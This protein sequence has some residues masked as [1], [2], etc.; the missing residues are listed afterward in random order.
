[1]N[2]AETPLDRWSLTGSRAFVSGRMSKGAVWVA[3]GVGTALIG[4]ISSYR[5]MYAV[6]A[7]VA[8]F[9]VIKPWFGLMGALALESTKLIPVMTGVPSSTVTMM[10]GALIYISLYSVL[11]QG[12]SR[13]LPLFQI[14]GALIII[15]GTG[16]VSEIVTTNLLHVSSTLN[17]LLAPVAAALV[18]R[19]MGKGAHRLLLRF[20]VLILLVNA[21]ACIWEIHAGTPEL[22]ASGLKYGSVIREIGGVLRSPGLMLTNADAGVFAGAGMLWLLVG[23]RIKSIRFSLIWLVVGLSAGAVVLVLSTSRSG[24]ILFVVGAVVNVLAIW[25]GHVKHSRHGKFVS[26]IVVALV[27]VLPVLFLQNGATS[28]DSLFKRFSAWSG[29]IKGQIS[30]FGLG[31]GTVGGSSFSQWNSGSSIFVDN[32][33]VSILLQYGLLGLVSVLVILRI[34]V[35]RLFLSLQRGTSTESRLQVAGILA[36]VIGMAVTGFVTEILD[37]FLAMVMLGAAIGMCMTDAADFGSDGGELKPAVPTSSDIIDAFRTRRSERL[38]G[39]QSVAQPS[40]HD[41]GITE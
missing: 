10:A 24:V 22:V 2:R 15:F 14:I 34:S 9:V 3:L 20:V 35:R 16:I 7:V 25:R 23:W 26:L 4:A 5:P 39:V 18:S 19:G 11:I 33:W 27:L 8:I 1:V 12:R 17:L 38:A 32:S 13:F 41:S 21:L 28:A 40:R 29:L 30:F 37:Y 6:G 36:V 31:G